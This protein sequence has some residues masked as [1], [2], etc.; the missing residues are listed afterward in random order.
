MQLSDERKPFKTIL[1]LTFIPNIIANAIPKCSRQRQAVLSHSFQNLQESARARLLLAIVV[2]DVD[3]LSSLA[4]IRCINQCA[5]L[6]IL[7]LEK[8][9]LEL[10]SMVDVCEAELDVRALSNV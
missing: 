4:R 5:M 9:P 1:F 10:E 7:V 8:L 2:L 6:P 3:T